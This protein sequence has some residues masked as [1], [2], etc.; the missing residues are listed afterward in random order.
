[1]LALLLDDAGIPVFIV[2]LDEELIGRRVRMGRETVACVIATE[3]STSELTATA[4][5]TLRPLRAIQ[6][7]RYPS[8]DGGSHDGRGTDRLAATLGEAVDLLLHLR[9]PLTPAEAVALRLAADGYTNF[10]ISRELGVS[11]SAI[12]ARL[13]G[14]YTKLHAADRTHAVAI[15]LRERWI[16]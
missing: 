3:Q 2:D 10:R 7:E 15:A 12:K 16:R 14:I 1:M 9:G 11:L 8:L 4:I 5:K 13:E 6:L